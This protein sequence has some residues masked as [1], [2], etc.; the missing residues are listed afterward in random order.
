MELCL[1]V[2][3]SPQMRATTQGVLEKMSGHTVFWGLAIGG[4]VVGAL[5]LTLSVHT[6]RVVKTFN[7]M[8]HP[9]FEKPFW[10]VL[11]SLCRSALS[12]YQ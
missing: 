9:L 8:G 4:V 5:F 3:F 2:F 6:R 11:P 12:L 7:E 1:V 10:Q